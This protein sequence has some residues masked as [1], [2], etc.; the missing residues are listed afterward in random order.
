[1]T[2]NKFYS[3]RSTNGLPTIDLS[4][5]MLEW[6]YFNRNS[7]RKSLLM[8]KSCENIYIYSGAYKILRIL[9]CVQSYVVVY[10]CKY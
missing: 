2:L 7:E 10:N 1:M 5:Q 3:N 4:P 8:F 6:Q 9:H